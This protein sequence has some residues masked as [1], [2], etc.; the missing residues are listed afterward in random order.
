MATNQQ[1]MFGAPVP[2]RLSSDVDHFR[3]W[4]FSEMPIL[5]TKVS[6]QG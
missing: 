1:T 3:S 4:H 5:P 6:H 2:T